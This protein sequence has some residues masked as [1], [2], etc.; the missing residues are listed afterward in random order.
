MD[1]VAILLLGMG[2]SLFGSGGNRSI[3]HSLQEL[4][5]HRFTTYGAV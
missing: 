3:C 2:S 4:D 5:P 1:V